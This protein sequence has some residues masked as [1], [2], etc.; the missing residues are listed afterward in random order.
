MSMDIIEAEVR[1]AIPA[2]CLTQVEAWLLRRVF[3]TEEKDNYLGFDGHW[4]L[5]DIY[6]GTP[7]SPDEE[8]ERALAASRQV[9]PELC[10]AVEREIAKNGEINPASVDYQAIFQAIIRR[11]PN[12]L[13]HISIARCYRDTRYSYFDEGFTLITATEIGSIVDFH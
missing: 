12:R 8:L 9:C 4:S 6:Q 13:D 10:A 7:V 2:K 11:H 5:N 1:P 3:I